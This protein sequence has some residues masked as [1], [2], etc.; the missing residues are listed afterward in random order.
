MKKGDEHPQGGAQFEIGP[1][2]Q[3]PVTLKGNCPLQEL[4]ISAAEAFDLPGEHL[5][6]PGHGFGDKLQKQSIFGS[7]LPQGAFAC[8]KEDS[9]PDQAFDQEEKKAGYPDPF[10]PEL[11]LAEALI[12]F[13]PGLIFL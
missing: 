5:F 13:F 11:E 8:P 9:D 1:V 2:E 3:P 7:S 10:H 12:R 6:Q 4:H